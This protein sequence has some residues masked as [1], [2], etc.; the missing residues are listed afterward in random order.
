MK[1][2]FELQNEKRRFLQ[3]LES[4][5]GDVKPL[6]SEQKTEQIFKTEKP[7]ED[8]GPE[9]KILNPQDFGVS[10]AYIS[11]DYTGGISLRLPF[12]I[13]IGSTLEPKE[14]YL[15]CDKQNIKLMNVPFI[16]SL[17]NRLKTGGLGL[18]QELLNPPSGYK[19]NLERYRGANTLATEVTTTSPYLKFS[20]AFIFFTPKNDLQ[21]TE[22]YDVDIDYQGV[23]FN[24]DDESKPTGFCQIVQEGDKSTKVSC[25]IING[26]L[27]LNQKLSS[28]SV[29]TQ[30]I[31]K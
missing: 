16:R 29:Q 4:K 11:S 19:V 15:Y 5:T 31:N 27:V 26:K 2:N 24:L 10:E 13:K 18:P 9:Q 28:N 30:G 6:I 23:E 8:N 7:I 12:E 21:D 14:T 22:L 17:I 1:K 25:S 3:L 20:D